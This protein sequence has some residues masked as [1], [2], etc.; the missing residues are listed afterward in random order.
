MSFEIIYVLRDHTCMGKVVRTAC[1]EH[2]TCAVVLAG[3][4]F[5]RWQTRWQVEANAHICTD[6]GGNDKLSNFSKSFAKLLNGWF[7]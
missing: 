6:G 3:L 4:A 1:R 5:V 2:A 7:F